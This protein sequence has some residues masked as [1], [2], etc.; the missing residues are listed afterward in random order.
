MHRLAARSFVEKLRS[1]PRVSGR[2]GTG[3]RCRPLSLG[4][5]FRRPRFCASARPKPA[6]ARS[7]TIMPGVHDSSDEQASLANVSKAFIHQ[8]AR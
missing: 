5:C 4:E 6:D 2:A 8:P 7:A 3:W 1:A